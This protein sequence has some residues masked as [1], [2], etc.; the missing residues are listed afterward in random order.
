LAL[1]LG[2]RSLIAM[3]PAALAGCT[4][5]TSSYPYPK[6]R[7]VASVD[8]ARYY[9]RYYIT[10]HIPYFAEVGYVGA[11]VDYSSHNP[12]GGASGGINDVYYA[13]KKTFSGKLIRF[14]AVDYVLPGTGNAR[15]RVT[16]FDALIGVPY[17][18]IYVAPDY[19]V[20]LVG[21]PNRSLGWIFSRDKTMSEA[22]Y[23]FYLSKFAA[24]GYD[25]SRF[26]RVPQTPEEIGRPEY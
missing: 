19:S 16:K 10:A 7:P 2:R 26:R 3:A 24:Q 8:L 12:A 4:L 25:I 1:L 18:I 14:P 23:R 17:V 11:Y 15:W 20:S 21:F 9:G 5:A 22:D 13:H 6:L